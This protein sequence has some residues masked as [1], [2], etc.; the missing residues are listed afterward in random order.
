MVREDVAV[1]GLQSVLAGE[2]EREDVEM[3][4]QARVD[5]EAAGSRVHARQILRVVNL[6]QR[7]PRPVVPVPVVEVLPDQ[8]VRLHREVRVHLASQQTVQVTQPEPNEPQFRAVYN[9]IC[10]FD[11]CLTTNF[12]G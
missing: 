5:G 1:D 9:C 12:P 8:R 10:N 3:T 2:A 11:T 7:Q 4:Q 6:L